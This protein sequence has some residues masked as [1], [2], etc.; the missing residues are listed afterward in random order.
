MTTFLRAL[1]VEDSED[2][3]MLLVHEL[4]RGGYDVTFERVDTSSA[5]EEALDRQPWDIVLSDYSMPSFSGLE[6]LKILKKRDVDIP[7]VLISGMIGEETAVEAMKAGAHDYLMKG[8]LTR[9]IPAIGRE[10]RDAE[11]RRESKRAEKALLKSEEKY[12]LIAENTTDVIWTMD[13][14][15]RLT[16]MSPS[17]THLGGYSVGEAIA[18]SLEEMMAPASLAIAMEAFGEELAADKTQQGEASWPRVLELEQ[19]RKDGSTIWTESTIRFLH[20]PEG[21]PIGIIGITRDI[22]ERKQ[23]DDRIRTSL[24]EK[25]V[26]LMEVHHRV[27]NNLQVI[28]S[29]INLQSRY[30]KDKESLAMFKESRD[31]VLSMA[32]VHEKLYRS[33]DLAT[34]DFADYIKSI[35]RHLFRTYGVDANA[36]RLNINCSDIFLSI[37]KAIPCGLI[38]NELVSNSL[39]HAFPDNRR[40]EVSI[41]LHTDKDNRLT[42][43]VSDTGIGL[44]ENMD[45]TNTET[46]G[47]RLISELTL[48]LKGDLEIER[49]GLPA[50]LPVRCTQTGGHAQ[51]GGAVFKIT[52]SV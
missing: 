24:R 46:L 29:L 38:I 3:A 17:V 19:R 31:R 18:L 45:I 43:I 41:D 35:T 23:A 7:F 50:G 22:T 40:G 27:K 44:P 14:N 28:S 5:M 52:F 49:D 30:I 1:I 48:Q 34:I 36:V 47:L 39:K 21:Q 32:L 26:L 4:R 10:L 11:T 20:D 6:A 51:A 15:L 16:Y 42:L 8:N 12:R 37:D 33:E 2:D 13:M 25:E 9:L